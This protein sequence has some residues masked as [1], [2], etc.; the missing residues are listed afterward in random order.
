MADNHIK[1]YIYSVRNFNSF[2]QL[3]INRNINQICN[4][5]SEIVE[6]FRLIL[7]NKNLLSYLKMVKETIKAML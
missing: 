4:E 1:Q 3:I 7:L 6:R 5:E 2:N